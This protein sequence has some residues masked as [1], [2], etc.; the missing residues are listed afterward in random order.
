LPTGVGLA[1]PRVELEQQVFCGTGFNS[2]PDFFAW[3]EHVT[4][5]GVNYISEYG[6][7][8]RVA[9]RF[10]RMKQQAAYP[11][12]RAG[13]LFFHHEFADHQ[14]VKAGAVK[15]ADCVGDGGDNRFTA[16]IK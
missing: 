7:V 4:A 15:G 3:S 10:R 12:A 14:S 11:Q 13:R 16:K 8:A 9:Q 2:C 6:S 5:N 1:R